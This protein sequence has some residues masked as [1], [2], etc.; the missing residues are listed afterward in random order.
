[1]RHQLIVTAIAARCAARHR[2]QRRRRQQIKHRSLLNRR[3]IVVRQ[4]EEQRMRNHRRQR[5]LHRIVERADGCTAVA[6]H[7]TA[8]L[9]R[10]PRGLRLPDQRRDAQPIHEDV[11][12]LIRVRE[13]L[14]NDV[15]LGIHLARGVQHILGHVQRRRVAIVQPNAVKDARRLLHIVADEVPQERTVGGPIAEAQLHAVAPRDQLALQV[16]VGA[17][18]LR[19]R[20]IGQRIGAHHPAVVGH[21][22]AAGHAVHGRLDFA[23]RSARQAGVGEVRREQRMLHVDDAHLGAVVLDA[24]VAQTGQTVVHRMA[25][26]VVQFGAHAVVEMVEVAAERFGATATARVLVEAVLAVKRGKKMW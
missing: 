17:T 21:H 18:G 15:Q 23:Q 25:D 10:V 9:V 12:G 2:H 19:P 3:R 11:I 7:Q 22:A 8:L 26:V 13:Q 6:V 20:E 14:R 24:L 16:H 4:I 1:M 5:A